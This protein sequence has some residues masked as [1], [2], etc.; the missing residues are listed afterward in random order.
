[1]GEVAKSQWYDIFACI[2]FGFF[3]FLISIL[4]IDDVF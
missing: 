4:D 1:M 2:L 3:F